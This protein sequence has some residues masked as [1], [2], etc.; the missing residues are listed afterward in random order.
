MKKIV[1]TGA[2]G[3]HRVALHPLGRSRA[4]PRGRP[5]RQPRDPAV[6]LALRPAR[7]RSVPLR[8]GGRLH[9]AARAPLRDADVVVHMAAMTNAAELRDPGAGREG[10]FRRDGARRAGVREDGEPPAVPTRRRACTARR[11]TS[12][13]SRA[14]RTISSR[15]ARTRSSNA[16][17]RGAAHRAGRAH[18]LRF[19]TPRLATIYGTSTGMRFHTAVTSSSGRPARD[20]RSR[21]GGPRWTRSA[22][23][24]SFG[25]GPG[26]PVL[27]RHG[28]V[29][30]GHLQRAHGQ[31]DRA[32]HRR[33]HPRG[34]ARPEDRAGR[35]ADH[36]PAFVRGLVRAVPRSGFRFEGN[37][38][39]AISETV[40]LL[41][42]LRVPDA[43]RTR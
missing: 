19:V 39:K 33:G 12:S 27:H 10:Q 20:S 14:V 17:R 37:L 41:R 1:V 25:R 36:E 9:G 28:P 7:R 13:T 4:V 40:R 42:G 16:A 34:G 11:R 15:R 43:Q 18:G 29:S 35:L 30:M 32:R 26:A 22:L 3:P 38:P 5:G 23:S 31:R 6:P 24:G 2:L 8:G 21:S